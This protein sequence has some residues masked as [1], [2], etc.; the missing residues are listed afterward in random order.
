[1]FALRQLTTPLACRYFLVNL[2]IQ[3]IIP[4]RLMKASHPS[5]AGAQRRSF[6]TLGASKILVK[7]QRLELHCVVQSDAVHRCRVGKK[8]GDD[9]THGNATEAEVSAC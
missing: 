1:V 7:P 3:L 5:G 2:S 4:Q 9:R 6:E 8:F